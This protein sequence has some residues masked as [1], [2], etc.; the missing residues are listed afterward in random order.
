M[1]AR[2]K[3]KSRAGFTLAETL[4]AVMILLLVSVIVARGV[5][6][7]KNVYEKVTLGANAQV[8]LSTT[9]AALRDELGI[10]GNV[11][12]E[13]TTITYYS[14]DTGATSRIYLEGGPSSIMLQEYVGADDMVPANAQAAQARRLVSASAATGDLTVGY[15]A[16]SMSGGVITFSNLEVRRSS[17]GGALASLET[18]NIR[19][20]SAR[21]E[22]A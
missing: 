1:G 10:A 22:G 7:A 8:L 4:L 12:V 16:V 9:V 18:L 17:G 3:L 2:Q 14:A 15:A 6:V 21:G 13:G 5:P 20:I 19:N 11:K